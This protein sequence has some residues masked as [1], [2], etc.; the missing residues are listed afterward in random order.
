MEK[1]LLETIDTAVKIG[2]GAIIS[3]VFAYLLSLSNYNKE[4]DKDK[5]EKTIAFLE[6]IALKL[7]EADSKIAEG[8]HVFWHIIMDT[9]STLYSEK[10]KE[11]LNHYLESIA[12]IRHAEALASLINE[13]VIREILHELSTLI[14][15]VYETTALEN[16]I[17]NQEDVDDVNKLLEQINTVVNRALVELGAAYSKA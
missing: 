5:R 10:A 1:E 15:K 13:K 4:K 16:L 3:G 7:Q 6:D 2:L 11:S 17:E 8:T 9:E 12:L 14:V